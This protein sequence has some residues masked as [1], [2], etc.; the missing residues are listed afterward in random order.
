M[1][2][3]M[4]KAIRQHFLP[5]SSWKKLS[6]GSRNDIR[7]LVKVVGIYILIH[8]R[9]VA[10]KELSIVSNRSWNTVEIGCK[11][12]GVGKYVLISDVF[13]WYKINS[14]YDNRFPVNG[15]YIRNVLTY[16]KCSYNRYLLYYL[17]H[18]ADCNNSIY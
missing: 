13:L 9:F 15:S 10:Y 1:T 6:I 17:C 16:I 3:Q 14:R 12:L 2:K 7:S 18:F 5:T 11:N 4:I 8:L